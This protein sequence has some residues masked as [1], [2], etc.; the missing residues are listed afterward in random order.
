[1]DTAALESGEYIDAG[2]FRT[3]YH[4]AGTGPTL[5]FVHG[6]GP[7]VSAWANW[8]LALPL[9]AQRFHVVAP[10]LLGFGYSD[11]PAGMTYGKRVWVDHLIAFLDAKGIERAH[12]VGNSMGGGIA[13]ALAV[14]RPERVDR[15]VLMGSSGLRFPIT[16]GLDAVW[17]Y[18]PDRERMRRLIT[19][20]F[21]YDA[22]IATDD[23]VELRYAASVQPGFQESYAGMFPPPRQ[24]GVDDLATPIDAIARIT[25]PTLLI[26]GRDDR[27]IPL[28]VSYELLSLIPDAQLHVFGRCG[29]WTQIERRAEFTA[30]VN[31][32]LASDEERAASATHLPP[33]R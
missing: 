26:H 10:D 5:V 17:G 28:A 31:S 20:Y 18:E 4:E 30:L 1:M 13:L 8:R 22:S 16:P 25:S 33:L 14:E 11:R 12:I 19:E 32:F 15:L 23:L 7:G 9:F 6:S 24:N 27:V 3:H 29:H 2:G 21:A